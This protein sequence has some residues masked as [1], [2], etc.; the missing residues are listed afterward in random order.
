MAE[1]ISK[2]LVATDFSPEGERAVRHALAL[3]NRLGAPLAVVH[4]V[5]DPMLTGAWG[6][7]IYVP[8]LADLLQK[9]MAGAE[10]QLAALKETLGDSGVIETVVL[11]GRPAPTIVDHA[12]S[13]GFDLIV[14]GTHGRSGMAHM[15]MGSVAER[16]IRTAP[17]PV[18]VVPAG[19][20]K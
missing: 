15:M 13:G 11:S 18:L 2:I 16:V 8:P 20:A 19:R 14:M 6:T 3:G 10:R 7:E 4:V 17:C 12:R 9:A 5:E 1:R